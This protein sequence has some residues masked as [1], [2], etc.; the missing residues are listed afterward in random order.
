MRKRNLQD[1]ISV[2]AISGTYVVLLGLNATED[3][4]KRLLGFAIEREDHTEKERY[5]LKGF[6]TF[7]ETEPDPQPGSLHS[8]LEH[9]IQSFLWGDYS[10]KPNHSYTYRIRPVLGKPKRLEYG[11]DVV[12]QIKTENVDMGEH[13]I[14]FNRGAIASQAYARK[15]QNRAPDSEDLTDKATVW[16]SRG[17]MEGALEFISQAK[18]SRYSLRTA[19]YEFNFAPFLEAF[20]EADAAGADVKIIYEAGSQKKEGKMIPTSTTTANNEAIKKAGIRK[21]LV[22]PR[23]KRKNIPHNKFIVL[24]ENKIPIEVWTGSTNFTSSGFLGQSNVGHVVRNREVAKMYHDYWQQLAQDPDLATMRAWNDLNTPRP[25]VSIPRNSIT[26]FFSP[27]FRSK[28][29]DW[30]GDQMSDTD[31]TVMFTAAFGVNK[32]LAERFAED[33]DFLRFLITEKTL[34]GETAKLVKRDKDTII[35]VG[36]TLGKDAR[37]RRIPGWELDKWYMEEK[38][39]RR[40][41][42]VFYVHTKY[43]L[44]DALTKDP[45]IFTGSANFSE[46]SLLYNDENMLLIRGNTKVADVY[47][48]EFLRLFNHFYSRKVAGRL[49]QTDSLDERRAVNLDPTTQW[50]KRHFAPG[51]YH[52]LRRELFK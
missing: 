48:G 32:K 40:Q 51:R 14:F 12:V 15:F 26:P 1:G 25:D 20:K 9:P 28:M 44:L 52:C 19:V 47:L 17:L 24:L 13:A 4:R 30:Y 33:K 42:H 11:T 45:K 49:A 37:Q 36:T 41:G 27:R 6:R 2:H 5:W 39:Y 7:E 16:L 43:M 35:A 22:I 50:L 29:L 46:N 21:E 23:K 34:K 3:A 38:L 18:S 8:T 10:A 31:Q